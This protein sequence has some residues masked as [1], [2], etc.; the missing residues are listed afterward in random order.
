MQEIIL[1]KDFRQT[2][3]TVSLLDILFNSSPFR[4]VISFHPK[5]RTFDES[6]VEISLF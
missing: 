1:A 5:Q 6:F 3:Q 2:L 4:D